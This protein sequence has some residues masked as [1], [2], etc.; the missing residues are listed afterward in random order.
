MGLLD[1]GTSVYE[2][3]VRN[4]KHKQR[5]NRISDLEKEVLELKEELVNTKKYVKD[6]EDKL[7]LVLYNTNR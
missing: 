6:I 3:F 1:H 7:D 4:S 5:D 2:R